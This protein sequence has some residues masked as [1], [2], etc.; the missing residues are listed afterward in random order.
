MQP[1]QRTC[2]NPRGGT[3]TWARRRRFASLPATRPPGVGRGAPRSRAPRIA[4]SSRNGARHLWG[5]N[6]QQVQARRALDGRRHGD[7]PLTADRADDVRAACVRV[8]HVAGREKHVAGFALQHLVAGLRGM[9]VADL[10]V[11]QSRCAVLA[12]QVPDVGWQPRKQPRC[13]GPTTAP[14]DRAQ[15]ARNIEAALVRHR[16]TRHREEAV[17]GIA[18]AQVLT[19]RAAL[20]EEGVNVRRR[21]AFVDVCDEVAPAG[22]RLLRHTH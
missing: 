3:W 21:M 19:S 1:A 12:V 4:A 2:H 10:H 13:S 5:Q 22:K 14:M 17:A 7:G 18:L 15:I 16:H 8:R 11:P 9:G 20:R 6:R